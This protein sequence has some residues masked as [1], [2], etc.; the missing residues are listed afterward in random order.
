MMPD[1]VAWRRL[2]DAGIVSGTPPDMPMRSPWYVRALLGIGGWLAAGFVIAFLFAVLSELL[3]Q[4]AMAIVVG[5]LLVGA[6]TLVLRAAPGNTFVAQVALATSFA[7]QAVAFAG[8][9]E[10]VDGRATSAL[11]VA[12]L[13]AALAFIVPHPVHRVFSAA[14]AGVALAMALTL[15][16]AYAIAIGLLAAATGV[17]WMTELRWARWGSIVRPIAYGVTLGLVF[18]QATWFAPLAASDVIFSTSPQWVPRRAGGV[19]T[20]AVL[21]AI[22]I[23]LLR[24]WHR[25][26]DGRDGL[27]AIGAALA[28]AAASLDAPGIPAALMLVLVAWANGNRVLLALGVLALLGYTSA[29]YYMLDTALLV[30]SVAML[31]TGIALLAA[32]V[33]LSRWFLPD[34]EAAHVS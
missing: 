20:A 33:A 34:T 18:I 10:A 25:P 28:V 22:V 5:L 24:R 16:G 30:K 13:E 29:Y 21:P 11:A 14:A 23:A 6:A 2:A 12:G 3:R 15:S 7:G 19:L 9:I 27:A 1:E 4:P 26:L 17:V 32:R 31:G 8:I